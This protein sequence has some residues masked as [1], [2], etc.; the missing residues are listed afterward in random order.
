MTIA[1]RIELRKLGYTKEEVQEMIEQEKAAAEA[2]AEIGEPA[3]ETPE[4]PVQGTAAPAGD[5]Q[6]AQLLAAINGLTLALQGHKLNTTEQP[7]AVQ[8]TAADVFNNMLKG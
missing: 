6:T 7:V 2:P 3:P 8:E 1:Q 4:A 5:P